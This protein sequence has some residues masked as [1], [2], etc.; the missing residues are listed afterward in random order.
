[1]IFYC[2]T[3]HWLNVRHASSKVLSF[4]EDGFGRILFWQVD[5]SEF[6]SFHHHSLVLSFAKSLLVHVITAWTGTGV[7]LPV[8]DLSEMSLWFFST[9]FVSTMSTQ[10]LIFAWVLIE[11]TNFRWSTTW[12]WTSWSL[13]FKSIDWLPASFWTCWKSRMYLERIYESNCNQSNDKNYIPRSQLRKRMCILGAIFTAK[14][15]FEYNKM[16]FYLI[17]FYMKYVLDI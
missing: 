10:I 8:R 13:V 17:F 3:Y 16:E 5:R 11:V 12:W 14:M 4:S 15:N 7:P 6:R 1:M 9:T 2:M